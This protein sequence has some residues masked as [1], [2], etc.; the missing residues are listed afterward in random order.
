MKAREI[1][2]ITRTSRPPIPGDFEWGV[3][4]CFESLAG[5]ENWRLVHPWGW[6][7]PKLF[8]VQIDP[9]GKAGRRYES[10]Y[11]RYKSDYGG[12]DYS[13]TTFLDGP[14]GLHWR[15]APDTFLD[16]LKAKELSTK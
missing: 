1:P 2:G 5:R 8:R 11:R 13:A 6:L 7:S 14:P 4:K 15:M 16:A 3:L 10:D 12:D 9:E